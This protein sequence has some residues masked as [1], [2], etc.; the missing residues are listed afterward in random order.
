MIY[1]KCIKE[2]YTWEGDNEQHRFSKVVEGHIYGFNR[3]GDTYWIAPEACSTEDFMD[4]D[5]FVSFV[6]R[7]LEKKYFDE[8]FSID[9]LNNDIVKI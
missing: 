7:G 1:A 3:I 8:M 6:A 4:S 9:F 2:T 5:G